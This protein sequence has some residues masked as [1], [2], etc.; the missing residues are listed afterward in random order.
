MGFFMNTEVHYIVVGND[1]DLSV[2]LLRGF[3]VLCFAFLTVSA[4]ARTDFWVLL[5]NADIE[6]WL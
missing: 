5:Q 2:A 4:L 6:L 1:C 3:W